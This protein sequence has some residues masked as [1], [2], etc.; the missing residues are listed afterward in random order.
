MRYRAQGPSIVHV[1]DSA[2]ITAEA[3]RAGDS[4]VRGGVLP[5]TDIAPRN[6]AELEYA[7]KAYIDDHTDPI[8]DGT[9]SIQTLKRTPPREPIPGR[10]FTV[11]VTGQY[12]SFTAFSNLVTTDIIGESRAG[13]EYMEHVVTFGPYLRLDAVQ[14]YFSPVGSEDL[15]AQ[16]STDVPTAIDFDSVGTAF[17]DD[18]VNAKW[19][20]NKTSS[21]FE[22][23]AGFVPASGGSFEVRWSDDGWGSGSTLNLIQTETSQVFDVPRKARINGYYIK[24]IDPSG[25]TSRYPALIVI[26]L[27]LIPGA[28]SSAEI[29]DSNR[30]YPVISLSLPTDASDVYGVEIR[31]SDDTTVDYLFESLALPASPSSPGL[32]YKFNNTSVLTRSKTFYAYCFNLLREYSSSLGVNLD[33]P[34]PT[35]SGVGINED[36]Q[37]L[38]WLAADGADSYDAQIATDAGFTALAASGS[39]DGTSFAL[40][41]EDV[42]QT[43]YYRVRGEDSLGLTSWVSGSHTYSTTGP[44]GWDNVYNINSLPV[45]SSPSSDPNIPA[46]F[47]DFATELQAQSWDLWLLKTGQKF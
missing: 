35:P 16:R 18:P 20:G 5:N 31:D 30:L 39:L 43:R 47:S 19:T 38:T 34:A 40:A 41:L 7:V 27:P 42:V 15:Q 8:Y 37:A 24:Y 1:K 9:F 45:P 2:S 25:K 36:A 3:A 21:T 46:E 28:P 13:D 29:D 14:A 33:M 23:D 17:A 22:I 32:S 6:S 12:D 11:A 4:G 44:S 26:H 10:F